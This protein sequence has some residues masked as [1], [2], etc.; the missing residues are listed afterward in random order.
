MAL[1]VALKTPS[2]GGFSS[3]AVD[4]DEVIVEKPPFGNCHHRQSSPAVVLGSEESVAHVDPRMV[5]STYRDVYTIV[6][7]SN[8]DMLGLRVDGISL[9]DRT[10]RLVTSKQLISFCAKGSQHTYA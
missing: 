8:R 4:S 10:T 9:L 2:V 3:T 1:Q 5:P 7:Q 6:R